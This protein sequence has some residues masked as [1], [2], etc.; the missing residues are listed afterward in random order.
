MN[1]DDAL[2]CLFLRHLRIARLDAVAAGD[3][4]L[5][6]KLETLAG[7]LRIERDKAAAH[8]RVTIEGTPHAWSFPEDEFTFYTRGD[9][10]APGAAAVSAEDA[11]YERNLANARKWL[12]IFRR[13]FDA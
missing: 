1:L 11:Q 3:S 12:D 6:G 10:S 9:R 5:A 2:R 4:R 8:Y 13:N 7:A